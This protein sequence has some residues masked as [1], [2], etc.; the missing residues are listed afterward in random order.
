MAR[1]SHQLVVKGGRVAL[2]VGW[3]DCDVGIDDGRIAAIDSGLQGGQTIDA[4]GLW[5]MPGGIDAH[6]HLD[7]PVWGGAGNADDFESGSISAAFGGTTCIVP[8]GMPGPNMTTVDALERA[9]GCAAGRSIIDYGLHAVVTMGT[10][11]NVEAQLS[12]LAG[13]G[14]ASVK[15]FMTYQGFAVDDDLFFTVLDTAR[16]LGWIVMVHA[17]NDAAIR[18]TRQRLIELGRTEMRYHAV[19]HSEIM[20]REAT[21]RALAL[22]EMTGTR[23]TIVHV[24]SR[25]SAEEVARARQRGVDV[26]AETCPQYIFLGAADLARPGRDAARF[27][28]SPPPRTPHSREH[29]WRLL[30]D[31]GIDLWSSDHS[32]YYFADKIG[33]APEPGFTTTLSGIPG[34]ETRLPLLFSEGLLTGRLSLQRYLDL[35]SRNAAAIYGLDHRKG[36]IAPGLDA[37]LAL[38]DPAR[39]WTI[40]HEMLHSRVD[41]SPYEGKAVTGKPITMLL[42]GEPLIA[43]EKLQAQAGFG[44]FVARRPSDPAKAGTAVEDTTPW[45]D[46]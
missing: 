38:W 7:Q 3:R 39:K 14:I 28:F 42:R 27:V 4:A 25:Q 43:G 29:L 8:F 16:K 36:R 32:P 40:G 10:G 20:E 1:R 45:L 9:M 26:A 22:A 24:S 35:T 23:M 6:C 34:L 2:D 44:G 33:K 37:D 41:F 21:H 15:L 17:E 19:A 18:R 11:A 46:P 13:Q 30:A 31:G 12:Q 5:V